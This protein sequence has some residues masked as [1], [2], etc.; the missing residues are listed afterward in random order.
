MKKLLLIFVSAQILL[1]SII[2]NQSVYDI[3][4]LNNIGDSKLKGYVLQD[5]NGGNLSQLYDEI[6]GICGYPQECSLQLIKTPVS[7]DQVFL[8]NIYHSNIE[9]INRIPSIR[10]D[11]SFIYYS[12]TKED[13]VDSNGVFYTDLSVGRL[14]KITDK[15]GLHVAPYDQHVNYSQIIW[16][17][18]LNISLL[19]LLTI[20]VFFIFTFTRIK[21]NAV[22]KT[23]GYSNIKM[24][25]EPFRELLYLELLIVSVTVVIHYFYFIF[26]GE[27]E[28]VNRYFLFLIM[29]LLV[30][31]IVN[32]LLFLL[33]QIHVKYID[34]QSMIKNKVYSNRLNYTLYFTKVILII[35]IT[36]S[37]SYCVEAYQSYKESQQAIEQYTKLNGY[38]T[39]NGFNSDQND[40][41]MNDPDLMVEY[42]LRTKKLYEHFE[43]Q[44]QLYINDSVVIEFMNPNYLKMQGLEKKDIYNSISDNYIVAN[45]RYIGEFMPVKDVDGKKISDFQ[46]D[47]P[48]IIVPEKYRRE[49]QVVRDIYQEKLSDYYNYD[50]FYG[51]RNFEE[52][53]VDDIEIIYTSNYQEFEIMEKLDVNNLGENK[54]KDPIIIVDQG[55]F[56]GL[57]YL[58]LLNASNMFVKLEERSVFHTVLIGYQLDT[59]INVATLLTP[60]YD[61][62]HFIQ[63]ILYNTFLFSLLFLVTLLFVIVISNYVDVIANRHKY[64]M[65]YI[66]GFSMWKVFKDQTTVYILL[67]FGNIAYLFI[68]FNPFIYTI[69]LIVDLFVLIFVYQYEIKKDL[70]QV[71]KGG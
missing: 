38:F 66:L 40:Q 9:Q 49:E 14:K 10:P 64:S 44:D 45:Q 18:G 62:I 1:I 35:A 5:Y 41:I 29:F 68:S 54:L 16:Q 59:L 65:Q 6:M 15:I 21:I 58:D 32:L 67:L 22:K 2:F 31:V 39:S 19:V 42:S 24:I 33:T 20:V 11:R 47:R 71:V 48:L 12:L 55:K 34:I 60:L 61:E 50:V 52:I 43:K 26:L 30:A 37:I 13:F 28:I 57:Y 53:T 7:Q 63:F 69:F 4:E 56:G 70:H 23:L 51:V 17:N 27:I 36:V 8:Y 25:Y 3:V 46:S